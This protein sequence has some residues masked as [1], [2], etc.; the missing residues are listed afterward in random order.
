M[1]LAL[2]P[3]ATTQ[4]SSL[5]IAPAAKTIFQYFSG[6]L[7]EWNSLREV[8]GA[9]L[10]ALGCFDALCVNEGNEVKLGQ[11]NLNPDDIPPKILRSAHQVWV[12][13]ITHGKGVAFKTV[14]GAV[15]KRGMK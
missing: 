4:T 11:S 2:Q 3:V 6:G 13:S 14:F 9:Q 10:S 1:K 8:H 5:S 12:S 7:N 15:S